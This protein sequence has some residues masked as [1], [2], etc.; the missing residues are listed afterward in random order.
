MHTRQRFLGD[1]KETGDENR[2]STSKKLL[3]TAGS[4]AAT[5]LLRDTDIV[6]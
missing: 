4:A 3:Q 5:A 6:G 1:T 2:L